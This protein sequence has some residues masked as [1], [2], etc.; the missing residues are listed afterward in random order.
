MKNEDS[1]YELLKKL[2]KE[3]ESDKEESVL[4]EELILKRQ[5]KVEETHT[6]KTYLVRN[7]LVDRL[8]QKKKDIG[9]GFLTRFINYAI[10]NA[11]DEIDKFKDRKSTRLNSSHV[12]ISYAVFCL[13]K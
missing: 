3:L 11:L 1:K 12:S 10:E 2:L 5:K 13:K 4:P 6:R 7:E 8:E 9:H